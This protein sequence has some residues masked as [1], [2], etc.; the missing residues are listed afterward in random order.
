MVS[1]GY[2]LVCLPPNCGWLTI[3]VGAVLFILSF[4]FLHF[5]L[6]GLL[7]IILVTGGLAIW[8]ENRPNDGVTDGEA[9]ED[10]ATRCERR[11]QRR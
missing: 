1:I 4:S 8:F 5:E 11:A 10:G 3:L 9:A 6:F 7:Y 2:G